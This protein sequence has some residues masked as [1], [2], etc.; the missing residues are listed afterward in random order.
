MHR[1]AADDAL[2]LQLAQRK[3][4]VTSSEFDGSVAEVLMSDKTSPLKIIET[5][6]A[7]RLYKSAQREP[8]GR[9][10]DRGTILPSKFTHG[11]IDVFLLISRI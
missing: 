5:M 3:F 7:E 11:N 9:S 10:V 6:K 2:Q 8:L 4:G 1:E